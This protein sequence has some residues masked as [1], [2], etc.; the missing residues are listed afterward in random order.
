MSELARNDQGDEWTAHELRDDYLRTGRPKFAW[1]VCA[2]CDIEVTPAAIYGT[3][4]KKR[5][6]FS[7]FDKNSSSHAADCPY[8]TAGFAQYGITVA[9][10]QAHQ[11]KVDLPEKLVSPRQ[12]RQVAAPG[13][14]K[15]AGLATPVVI[16]QRVNGLAAT[17]TIPNQYTTSLLKTLVAARKRAIKEIY[18]L[19]KIAKLAAAKQTPAVFAELKKIPLEVYGSPSNYD[20]A[21]HKTSHVPWAGSFIYY[22]TA[23]VA[24]SLNGFVLTSLNLVPNAV[25]AGPPVP[26]HILVICDRANPVNRMEQSTIDELNAASG[27]IAGTKPYS[28]SWCSY[29]ELALNAAGAAYELTVTQPNH[30]AVY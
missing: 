6:Y 2:F 24:V 20:S 8:S 4:F 28:I 13:R 16:R 21:F 15:P 10:P 25:P 30:F 3:S 11:F 18:K 26:V 12:P 7:L 9:Q 5:P 1:W 22:G 23:N 19:P 17:S 29:G 27:T 14:N